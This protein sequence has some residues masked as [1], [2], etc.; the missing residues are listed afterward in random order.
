VRASSIKKK[1]TPVTAQDRLRFFVWSALFCKEQSELR[2][3][4]SLLRH[5]NRSSRA[6]LFDTHQ[7][8]N[9]ELSSQET[10]EENED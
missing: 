9:L 7:N 2:L 3:S 8:A 4:Q 6:A 10:N 5:S 1:A